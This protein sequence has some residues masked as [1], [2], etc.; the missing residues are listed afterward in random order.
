MRV[1]L[2][3]ES[4]EDRAVPAVLADQSLVALARLDTGGDRTGPLAKVGFDL[5]LL[6]RE[7]AAGSPPSNSLLQ[8]S[9][10]YVAVEAITSDTAASLAA[11]GFVAT[12]PPAGVV[13]G[14]LPIRSIGA[15]AELASVVSLRP[16]YRPVTSAGSLTSQGDA[17]QRS[18]EVRSLLG[19]DGSGVSVGVISD[20]YNVRGGASADVLSGD[21]PANVTVLSE[22]A[23]GSDEG[24]AMLQVIHDVAPGAHLL[25]TAAGTT[26]LQ[27]ATS[28][29]ALANA[30]ADIIVDDVTF[31]SE[32]MFQD[33]PVAQAVDQ[34][35]AAGVVYFSAAG[36]L[37][38]Q[39]YQSAYRRGENL[40]SSGTGLIPTTTN[41]LAHD[42]DPGAGVDYFQS[43]TLP[44]GRTTISFQ[45]ADR[46][47]SAGGPGA[48]I[49]MDMALF[50]ENGVFLATIGGFT[51]NVGGDPTEVFEIDAGPTGGRYQIALGKFSVNSADPVLVK[52]V[53]FS[54]GF[55]QDEYDTQ[56]STVFGHANAVGA[57]AVGAAR[58]SDTPRFGTD[59]GLVRA[60]SGRG[61]TPIITFDGTGT[62]TG[63]STRPTPR[64]V[65]PDGV[66]T[67]FFGHDDEPDG[68]PNF[69]GTSAAAPHAAGIA[70]LMLQ[71]N[72]GLTPTQVVDA[73]A[74]TAIDLGPR[75]FDADTGAGLVQ[76]LPAVLAV[77]G[78][79][80]VTLDGGDGDDRFLVRRD[81]TGDAVE[82]FKNDALLATIPVAKLG[83]V[84]VH[85][86]AGSDTLTVDHVNGAPLTS[87]GLSFA[88]G[89]TPGDNDRVVVTGYSVDV[90]VV[91]H[92][93]PE[94]GTVQI[95][96]SGLISFAEV[97]PVELTGDAADLIVNLPTTPNPDVSVGDDGGSGDPDGPAGRPGFSA[98]SG[99]TFEYTRF[100]NP[101]RTL[102][103]GLG[104]GGDT[105]ALRAPDAGFA[106]AV[107]VVGGSGSDSVTVFGGGGD[108]AITYTPDSAEGGVLTLARGP[109]A[110]S[111]TLTDIESLAADGL[112][113]AGADA[114]TVNAP[115]AGVTFGLVGGSG[116]VNVASA[117]GSALL[118]LLYRNIEQAAV[119]ATV[120]FVDGTAYDD[121][122]SIA[123]DGTVSLTHPGGDAHSVRVTA[124]RLNLNGSDGA[125]HFTV[126]ADH[127]F[128]GGVSL[129]GGDTASANTLQVV[130]SGG[131]LSFTPSMSGQVSQAGH[132][133][134]GYGR[135][136]PVAVDAGTGRLTLNSSAPNGTADV[137]VTGPTTA[138]AQ[139]MTAVEVS[140]TAASLVV[141]AP[142][143]SAAD[144][145]RVSVMAPASAD[146][147]VANG[148][149]CF[150]GFLPVTAGTGIDTL[151]VVGGADDDTFTVT[152]GPLPLTIVGGAHSAGDT[153]VL[154]ATVPGRPAP[155]AGSIATSPGVTYLGIERF[156]LGA[157]P[158][159]VPDTATTPEGLA[160]T[161]PVLGNDDGLL[162]GPI[163]L[164]LLTAPLVGSAVV[165]GTSILYTPA[166]GTNGTVTFGYRVT[167]T[168]GDSSDG[169]VTVTVTVT[170]TNAAPSAFSQG[171]SVAANSSAVLQLA[172]D[173]GDPEVAQALTFAVATPPAHGTL[174]GFN[175][176]TGH[177]T[178]TPAPGY[179]G[180]DSFT[181]TVTDDASAGGAPRTSTP[182]TVFLQVN[183]QNRA[184]V[185][186]ADS[187]TV[188]QGSF[189]ASPSGGVRANDFDPDGEPFTISLVSGPAHGRLTLERNGSYTYAP[190]PGFFGT[191][192]FVYAAT[193]PHGASST[194][195]VT[196]TVTP[197]PRKFIATGA[198][199]GGGPH[200]KVFDAETG[201]EVYSFFAYD[202][203]FRGGVRVA[204]GDVNGDG[205]P[206]IV[207][208]PG[209]GG[210]PHVKVF[211]GID[212]TE[213]A[214]FFAFDSRFRSGANIAVG[215]IDADGVT[216][217]VAAA[218]P[219]GG[220][221]VRTFHVAGG[222]AEQI[223]GPLGSFFAFGE[224]FSGGVNVA[225]GDFDGIAG[226]EIIVGAATLSPE[227][228]VFGRG[229]VVLTGFLAF[230]VAR[231]G[232]TVA[233]GDVDGDGKADVVVGPGDGG[234]PVVR[235]F[236]GGT[237][238]LM[239]STTAF[240][241]DLRGGISVATTHGRTP[242]GR[243]AVIVA[244]TEQARS[245][246]VLDPKADELLQ[247]IDAYAADFPG[248]V[249]VGAG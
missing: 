188:H 157:Q 33:G 52:Y 59:P 227:V 146:A 181:F 114:L 115:R 94:T 183:R 128:A 246:L 120:V 51:S 66:N 68:S 122:I 129:D 87:A 67:T 123:A 8:V 237:G 16:A 218:A 23:G 131:D 169:T 109:A 191:D 31:P 63:A 42:F 104:H 92:D 203:S 216:E 163:T 110:T 134:V 152:P 99:S 249:F 194:A 54:D 209:P 25:F 18:D 119:A 167:D 197:T 189:T 133:V 75:G 182:A 144:G 101:T 47:A 86:G 73:L 98:V 36:N 200:V 48:Q 195:T 137:R 41:F 201:A 213:L 11:L 212:L 32:P 127:A 21:L 27:L 113:Q 40:G 145:L 132:G 117:A 186:V 74:A 111:F 180:P 35:V 239:T 190:D 56:S 15:A 138:T 130:G 177:V 202:P 244:P 108:D 235:V 5:A 10:G 61:G 62:P 17:A 124:D 112:G 147:T 143:F 160:V 103:V 79:F 78:P 70:A 185:A 149:V 39:S 50:D 135:F 211:S 220:S 118:A 207:T 30:G 46:Y 121:T 184:P 37:G 89:E 170:A 171:V 105:V 247:L 80:D 116:T 140:L 214:S 248:G 142:T 53:A 13:A 208:T 165:V 28:I 219:G 192:S 26:Q 162:D 226:D 178:Y 85:G 199:S 151:T 204:V 24:R 106:A 29:R 161:I 72:R 76:A 45:W 230:D 233:A 245:V 71:A 14:W 174:S 164:T 242:D 96:T 93:G 241:E 95:G 141:T 150:V 173:D 198:G 215:D 223:T 69:T 49:D 44:A 205:V 38:R 148:S 22:G 43:V 210:G 55:V 20:S 156:V 206:D 168:N 243:A 240:D 88:G 193:D 64:F 231:V 57:A 136:G 4:L 236:R 187:V 155:G 90:V 9:G 159:A 58:Y 232:I 125:D 102:V 34:V 176:A 97:E 65:A 217:V 238:E 222:Q 1:R 81:A 153:L 196:I 224:D 7:A 221:H 12:T 172:G 154:P 84:T 83:R 107:R 6:G 139:L 166:P 3:A 19:L 91:S 158:A 100:R 82:F 60:F 77:G 228:K 2:L 179:D 126:A 225:L 234:G 229:G 175:P